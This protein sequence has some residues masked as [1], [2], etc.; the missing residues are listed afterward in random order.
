MTHAE[1]QQ[2]YRKRQR[3]AEIDSIGVE[4][5]A[6]RVALVGS[7]ASALAQL[8]TDRPEDAQRATRLT[9]ARIIQEIVTRYE[10]KAPPAGT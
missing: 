4:A 5:E 7:L 6:S 10:I 3:R 9:V 1:R 8:D 2:E